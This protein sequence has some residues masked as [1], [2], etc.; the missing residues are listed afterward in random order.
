MREGGGSQAWGEGER[1]LG[2][3]LADISIK[4]RLTSGSISGPQYTVTALRRRA[5]DV[6]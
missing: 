3:G 2:L 4:G 6:R 5:S 1:V